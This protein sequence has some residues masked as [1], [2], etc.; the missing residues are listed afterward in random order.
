MSDTKSLAEKYFSF[1]GACNWP[2]EIDLGGSAGKMV[3]SPVCVA[4]FSAL[5]ITLSYPGWM[6][7][8]MRSNLGEVSSSSYFV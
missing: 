5:V 6:T 2:G 3:L 4:A 7:A 1:S 8:F